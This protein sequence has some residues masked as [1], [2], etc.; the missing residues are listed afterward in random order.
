MMRLWLD[1]GCGLTSFHISLVLAFA[2]SS[3]QA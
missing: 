1:S 3:A 2:L